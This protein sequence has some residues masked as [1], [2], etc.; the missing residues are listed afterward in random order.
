M[1]EDFSGFEVV[2]K[3]K[4]R[5]RK[6][7]VIYRMYSDASHWPNPNFVDNV[8]GIEGGLNLAIRKGLRKWW[9]L[10]NPETN[11][12]IDFYGEKEKSRGIKEVNETAE[13]KEK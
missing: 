8:E 2:S 4:K 12:V 3:K 5:V 1:S 9:H 7:K 11:E 13:T 10:H 6:P